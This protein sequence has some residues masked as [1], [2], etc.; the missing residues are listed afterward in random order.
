MEKDI[1]T[2]RG[3]YEDKVIFAPLEDIKIITSVIDK[4]E[5]TRRELKKVAEGMRFVEM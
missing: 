1:D 4:L 2:T 3:Q 5:T